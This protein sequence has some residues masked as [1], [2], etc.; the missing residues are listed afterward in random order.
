MRRRLGHKLRKWFLI[1]GGTVVAPPVPV[2]YVPSLDF[3]DYRNS[4]Y[5]GTLA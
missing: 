2:D 4:Q 5:L 3:S 1:G